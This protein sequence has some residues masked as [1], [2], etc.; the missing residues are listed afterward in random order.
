M[1]SQRYRTTFVD[2]RPDG[3]EMAP[4]VLYIVGA[5]DAPFFAA[6]LCPCGCRAALY[7]SL[8]EDDET[9]LA[10]QGLLRRDT[11]NDPEH[12]ASCRMSEPLLPLLGTG[13]MGAEP[14]VRRPVARGGDRQTG[15][16]ACRMGPNIGR[17]RSRRACSATTAARSRRGSATCSAD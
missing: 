7:M 8:V 5:R 9:A 15:R 13:A 10:R 6:M 16:V 3:D 17:Q 14:L 4:R 11:N 2:E 12:L 1:T